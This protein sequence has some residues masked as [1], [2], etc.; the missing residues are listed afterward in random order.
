MARKFILTA[1][2]YAI[3][4]LLLGIYMVASKNHGQYV[5][6]THFMLVGFLLS[7]VLWFMSQT[8]AEQFNIKISKCSV[9]C[10][11]DGFSGFVVR[12]IPSIW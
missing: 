5:T 1:F 6:H 4:G 8:L 3:L 11:P 9:L 7:F 10:S 2:G 12:L